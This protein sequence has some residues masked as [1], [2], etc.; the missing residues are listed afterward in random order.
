MSVS[1]EMEGYLIELGEK[2]DSLNP[3]LLKTYEEVKKQFDL[4][5]KI[6]A[7]EYRDFVVLTSQSESVWED[8]KDKADFDMFLPYLEKI[9]AYDQKIHRLLGRE[10]RKSIQYTP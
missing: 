7:D 6:P 8:A 4:S 3:I 9:V 1:E 5:K 10:R 2:K